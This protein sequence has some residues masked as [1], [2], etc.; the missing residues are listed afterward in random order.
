MVRHVCI[1][2]LCL[3]FAACAQLGIGGRD[4]ASGGQSAQ[5]ADG[6]DVKFMENIAQANL[7]E[8]ATGKLAVSKAQSGEVRK[9]A[10]HMIDEHTALLSEGSQL[11]SAKG[12]PVPKSPDLKHQAAA[13]KLEAM[14]GESFDRAYMQQMVTDHHQ[15]LELLKQA[16]SQAGDSQLR[17]HAQK[18][19]PHVQQHLDMARQIAG[20]LG[21]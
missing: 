9:F 21:S 11:A 4:G 15:T 13:K 1:L 2:I 19:I 20:Q 16:S 5:R 12:I 14:S 8:I 10:Q 18:A 7:A 3:F 6:R 17:A